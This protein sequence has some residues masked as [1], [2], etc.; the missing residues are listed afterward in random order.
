MVEGYGEIFQKEKLTR[1][2]SCHN[3]DY[4]ESFFHS[5]LGELLIP[6]HISYCL[7][8]HMAKDDCLIRSKDVVLFLKIK[9]SRLEIHKL[10]F[11]HEEV[12][13]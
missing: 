12:N 4:H 2:S 9:Y 5:P 11:S 3:T 10:G 7:Q 13:L 6:S 1:T 8:T